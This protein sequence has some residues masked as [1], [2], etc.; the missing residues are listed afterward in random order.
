MRDINRMSLKELQELETKVQ[1]AKS[2]VQDRT[3]TE[4][5][6]RIEDIARQ[7]GFKLGDLF[8]GRGGKGRTVPIK[9]ANPDDPSQT[10]TGRGRMPRWLAAKTR[11]GE[12]L[13]KFKVK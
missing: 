12:R 1:K 7:A 8:S 13:D 3:R 9:Y 2:A 11:A 5:R 6:R 10:W 4:L